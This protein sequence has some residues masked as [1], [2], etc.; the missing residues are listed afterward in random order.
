V[1]TN[2]GWAAVEPWLSLVARVAVGLVFVIAGTTKIG[3]LAASGRAVNAYQLMPYGL[4]K[5]IGAMLPF[6]E[7]GI[8][9]LLIVGFATRLMAI[10]AAALLV[11]Y[12]A[13]IASVWARGLAI[14]CGCFSRGGELT[15]GQKPGY[16]AD[17]ARDTGLLALAVFTAW[18]PRSRLSVDNA[19]DRPYDYPDQHGTDS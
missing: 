18:A 15:G 11:V 16:G 7:I 6:V 9:A 19:I 13:G 8:G 4:A 1:V 14:D 3:D 2:T 5:V 10:V 17:I 12:I